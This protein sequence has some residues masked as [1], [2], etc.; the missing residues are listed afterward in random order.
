MMRMA[1]G[2]GLASILFVGAG[3][4][5]GQPASGLSGPS[6]L[7]PGKPIRMLANEAGGGNN[8]TARII[9]QGIAGPLGQPVIVDGRPA[10]LATE[11]AAKAAPDGY[12][13]IVAG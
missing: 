11:T 9:A 5:F 13:V 2:I 6:G 7:Y 8:L 3:A 4:A 1:Y 12:T 10:M